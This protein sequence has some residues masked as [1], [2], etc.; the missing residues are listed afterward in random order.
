METKANNLPKNNSTASAGFATK[1]IKEK[2]R[3][4][5]NALALASPKRFV[6][7]KL[8]N[9]P[10]PKFRAKAKPN[11]NTTKPQ[12]KCDPDAPY[13]CIICNNEI[14]KAERARHFHGRSHEQT[15]GMLRDYKR[16]YIRRESHPRP[17]SRLL[18]VNRNEWRC[19]PCDESMPYPHR[20]RTMQ[21]HLHAPAHTTAMNHLWVAFVRHMR[22]AFGLR[23]DEIPD[24]PQHLDDTIPQ[25]PRDTGN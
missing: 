1:K 3:G 23:D 20:A 16:R 7:F 6:P 11:L 17:D 5:V 21:D 14:P 8:E 19:P 18:E 15:F 4:T 22:S 25:K 10:E 9:A 2:T 13:R 12:P 24:F